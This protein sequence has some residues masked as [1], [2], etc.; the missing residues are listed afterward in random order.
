MP[1]Y[2]C[3]AHWSFPFFCDLQGHW[4]LTDLPRALC[5]LQARGARH[6]R[7]AALVQRH[8]ASAEL[9]IRVT[10]GHLAQGLWSSLWKQAGLAV[11][12]LALNG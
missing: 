4:F 10:S 1:S 8:R 3:V 12:D 11:L 6:L 5:L 2:A 9:L 7:D